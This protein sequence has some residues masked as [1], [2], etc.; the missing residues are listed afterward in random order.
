MSNLR[1]N[2]ADWLDRAR[3]LTRLDWALLA[4]VG[5][6]AWGLEI[7]H[8]LA[9]VAFFGGLTYLGAFVACLPVALTVWLGWRIVN[10]VNQL[11]LATDVA[12][13]RRQMRR[14]LGCGQRWLLRVAALPRYF[15]RHHLNRPARLGLLLAA[16]AAT[17]PWHWLGDALI[18][19]GLCLAVGAPIAV[20]GI[21][22]SRARRQ[23][24]GPGP[25]QA[26]TATRAR[27]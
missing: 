6:V 27:R 2:V 4:L 9:Q 21:V 7:P 23:P 13:R 1:V 15:Q 11:R 5:L 24:L 26:A 25:A 22:V 3:R 8:W 18:G 17:R 10:Q 19:L 14:S 20:I 12:A 16:V